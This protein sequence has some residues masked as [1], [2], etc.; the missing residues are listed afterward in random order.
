MVE[1]YGE[2]LLIVD[3]DIF[4][5]VRLVRSNINQLIQIHE[6]TPLVHLPIL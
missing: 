3:A 2:E 5:S 1:E 4:L 6:L